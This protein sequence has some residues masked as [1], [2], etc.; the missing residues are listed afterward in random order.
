MEDVVGEK[1]HYNP[2]NHIEI[3]SW[4]TPKSFPGF[5]RGTGGNYALPIITEGDD[6]AFP[7]ELFQPPSF[8]QWPWI[9]T[10]S[11]ATLSGW[12][13]D[14]YNAFNS[15]VPTTVSLPNFLYELKD[16]KGMIP[17]FDRKSLTKTASNNFLAFEFGVKPFISDIK[18][19]VNMADSVSKRLHHLVQQQKKTSHLTFARDVKYEEDFS[20][21]RNI[22]SPYFNDYVEG[23]MNGF[24][25][26][27]TS[28]RTHFQIGASLY[29]DLSDLEDANSQLK[30][31]L[32]SGGFNHPAR[33]V[34][35]AIPY[36]FV[37]DWFFSVGKLLD[38]LNVQPFG[39]EWSVTNVGYSLKSEATY[40]VHAKLAN[41]TPH[42]SDVFIPPGS[43]MMGTVRVKSY[44]RKRGFPAYSLFL[45]D[46]LLSPEQLAL[47]LAM[48]EQRRR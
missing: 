6:I 41:Y 39:G 35:N 44:V 27:R 7:T 4:L 29:Q 21:F 15:Q 1:G 18:N 37:V 25:F 32:S 45:T 11:A 16:M 5:W 28:A 34:W 42:Y 46:G 33:V 26:K 24:M 38:T 40:T 20:F 31:L 2:C 36:S 9:P 30:A 13:M 3:D 14:A 47:G 19:I 43:S 17:S 8:T 48:L 12:S 10:V 22:E 23:A